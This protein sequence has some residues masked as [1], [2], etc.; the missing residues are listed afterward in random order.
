MW[1]AHHL[2][3]KIIIQ[4]IAF[5]FSELSRVWF[6]QGRKKNLFQAASNKTESNGQEDDNSDGKSGTQDTELAS[7]GLFHRML[8][9]G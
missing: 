3:L 1:A 6:I 8:A 5:A 4:E 9:S 2:G 7:A